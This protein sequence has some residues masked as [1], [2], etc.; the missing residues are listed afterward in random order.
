[1]TKIYRQNVCIVIFNKDKKLL[2]CE[3]LDTQGK[4]FAWQFPQ[5]GIDEGED[6]LKAAKREAWEETSATSLAFIAQTSK[7]I[8]YNFPDDVFKKFGCKYSGQNQ[9]WVLFYFNGEDSEININTKTPEF[10]QWKWEN[11]DFVFKNVI[12]FKKEVYKKGLNELLPYVE[13]YKPEC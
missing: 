1:M 5:G 13:S 3:R 8:C 12:P 6:V 4:A 7:P 10:A 11:A 2:V 9:N